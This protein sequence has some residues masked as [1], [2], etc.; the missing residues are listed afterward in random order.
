MGDKFYYNEKSVSIKTFYM[1]K[2]KN[3]I[4]DKNIPQNFLY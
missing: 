4:L 1:K 3:S 2:E